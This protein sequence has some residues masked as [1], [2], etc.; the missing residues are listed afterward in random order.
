MQNQIS[1]WKSTPLDRRPCAE[2]YP[3]AEFLKILHGYNVPIVF[4]SDAHNPEDLGRDFKE[5]LILAKKVGYT[6]ACVF[7]Q[8]KKALVKI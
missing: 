1:A 6:Y 7:G 4:G 5:A 3:S 2:I 8:R